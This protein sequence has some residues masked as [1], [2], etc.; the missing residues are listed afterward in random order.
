MLFKIIDYFF[1]FVCS[2][3]ILLGI[4][5]TFCKLFPTLGDDYMSELYGLYMV[6]GI[7]AVPCLILRI[8]SKSLWSWLFFVFLIVVLISPV[9]AFLR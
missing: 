1:F 9:P 6:L 4:A 8:V 7:A 3:L 5:C 2:C